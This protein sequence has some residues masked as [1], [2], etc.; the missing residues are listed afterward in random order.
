MPE[1][2]ADFKLFKY[3]LSRLD[4]NLIKD[5]EKEEFFK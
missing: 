4:N 3:F 2:Q 1:F 5:E